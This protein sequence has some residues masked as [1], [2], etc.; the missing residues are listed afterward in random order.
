LHLYSKWDNAEFNIIKTQPTSLFQQ[1]ANCGEPQFAEF[2]R[3]MLR[4]RTKVGLDAA[5]EEGRIGDRPNLSC[6]QQSEIRKMITKGD[7]IAADAARSVVQG[8]PRNGL[9]ATGATQFQ[10]GQPCQIARK[11]L[12]QIICKVTYLCHVEKHLRVDLYNFGKT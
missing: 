1:S 7:K 10:E 6:Q 8:S 12:R 4:E 2:D 5:R 9:A 3:A 11:V